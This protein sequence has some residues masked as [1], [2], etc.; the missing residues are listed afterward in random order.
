MTNIARF[1]ING[2]ASTTGGI[3]VANSAA[4]TFALEAS[5]G[6]VAQRVN[7]SVYSASDVNSPLASKDAPTLVL[8]NGAGSTGQN[9]QASTPNADVTTTAPASGAHSYIV[10]CTVNGGVN[11]EGDIDAEYVFERI[12]CVRTG[13]GLRKEIHEESTQYSQR[14]PADA[15]NELVD[16]YASAT[17]PSGTANQFITYN[18]GWI[19][20]NDLVL[21]GTG[22]RYVNPAAPTSG[23]GVSLTVSGGDAQSGSGGSLTVAP[24]EATPGDDDGLLALEDA[25]GNVAISIGNQPNGATE[26]YLSFYGE[27]P[28][29]RQTVNWWNTDDATL[30]SLMTALVAVGIIDGAELVA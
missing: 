13:A 24:G 29:A 26:A 3:D 14:G 8:D 25:Q 27:S 28:I 11:G 22:A 17:M 2:T 19:A 20:T 4:L 21:P 12:V 23:A 15:Q 7:Y 9:V 18:S 1:T 30:K 16:A 6:V 5:P 10:R